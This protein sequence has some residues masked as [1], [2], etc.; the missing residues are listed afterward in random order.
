LCCHSYYRWYW[1]YAIHWSFGSILLS[2]WWE[3]HTVILINKHC[4]PSFLG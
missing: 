1:I 2:C 3:T 4:T